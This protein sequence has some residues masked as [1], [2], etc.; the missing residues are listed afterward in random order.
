MKPLPPAALALGVHVALALS[1]GALGAVKPVTGPVND[2]VTIAVNDYLAYRVLL[3]GSE[4][5]HYTIHV[6]LGGPIDIF[7]VDDFNY[8]RYANA[9][10]FQYYNGASDLNTKNFIGFYGNSAGGIF[11]IILD[12]EAFTP[13]ATPTGPVSATVQISTAPD[14][15]PA[16]AG[17]AAAAI[18]VG[19]LA[20]ILVLV[21]RRRRAKRAASLPPPSMAFPPT[22]PQQPF[23]P[24]RGPPP[25]GDQGFRRPPS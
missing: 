23:Q 10:S 25:G 4:D 3:N 21:M 6:T 9:T 15:F 14:S 11:Y 16:W 5:V 7:V 18:A 24:P 22:G 8:R 1:P 12:N 2:T 13:S 17:Y 19:A 20:V